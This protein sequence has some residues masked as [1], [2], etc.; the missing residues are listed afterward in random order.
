MAQPLGR[1]GRLL[2][3]VRERMAV[4]DRHRAP[5]GTVAAVHLGGADPAVAALLPATAPRG[6][7]AR[8]FVV[9]EAGPLAAPCY[10]ASGQLAAVEGERVLLNVGG[11]YLVRR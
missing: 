3:Q 11:D 9:I 2:R 4:Y 6:L 5:V 7:A 1:S 8:G 10:A